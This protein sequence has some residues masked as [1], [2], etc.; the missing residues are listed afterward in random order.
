MTDLDSTKTNNEIRK[1]LY[2]KAKAY[3]SINNINNAYLSR[4]VEII[5]L[6]K[7][8][9]YIISSHDPTKLNLFVE[10]GSG[11]GLI[12]NIL[13]YVFN[14]TDNKIIAVDPNFNKFK[15]IESSDLI[16]PPDY[17]D[18]TEIN[19]SDYDAYDHKILI[20]NWTDQDNNNYDMDAIKYLNFDY[21][22]LLTAICGAAGSTLL[23]YWLIKEFIDNDTIPYKSSDGYMM[24]MSEISDE[25]YNNLKPDQSYR[26]LYHEKQILDTSTNTS[27]V[28]NQ[29]GSLGNMLS[30]MLGLPDCDIRFIILKKE[31]NK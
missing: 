28:S 9:K 18:V 13:S 5:G 12:S 19:L 24:I 23:N 26:L 16:Y 8:I 30:R 20:M 1:E 2:V 4:G 11:N 25:E 29:K 27:N 15:A 7:Y 6:K 17:G 14:E 21:L 22:V 10:I 31:N 3:I